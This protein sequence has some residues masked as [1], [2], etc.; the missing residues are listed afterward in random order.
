MTN[1]KDVVEFEGVL[2]IVL[3]TNHEEKLDT[4]VLFTDVDDDNGVFWINHN[5]LTKIE[6]G[7]RKYNQFMIWYKTRFPVHS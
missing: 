1:E 5:R 3:D 7:S 2:G 6:K 4:G